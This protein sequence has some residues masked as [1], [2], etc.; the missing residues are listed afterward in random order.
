[1]WPRAHRDGVPMNQILQA[2][3]ATS[4]MVVAAIMIGRAR[5]RARDEEQQL[6]PLKTTLSLRDRES[7]QNGTGVH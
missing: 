2:L 6:P 4:L 1:M 5:R 3:I 7:G